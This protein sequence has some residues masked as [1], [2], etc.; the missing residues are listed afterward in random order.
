MGYVI[1]GRYIGDYLG[2]FHEIV[3]R[4]HKSRSKYYNSYFYVLSPVFLSQ[5]LK[6]STGNS[7]C[8]VDRFWDCWNIGVG[9]I[10]F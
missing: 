10:S 2:V 7:L 1:S 3:K 5:A 9:N 4:L 6:A 8:N